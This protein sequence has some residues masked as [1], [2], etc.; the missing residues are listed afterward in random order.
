[1]GVRTCLVVD[2]VRPTERHRLHRED[3][4]QRLLELDVR[5]HLPL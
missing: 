5:D 3:L 2:H 4:L 1:M